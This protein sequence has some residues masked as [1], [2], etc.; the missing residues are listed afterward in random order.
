MS[1]TPLPSPPPH[2]MADCRR[3]SRHC[4]GYRPSGCA[5]GWDFRNNRRARDT[6]RALAAKARRGRRERR[7]RE[8]A[9][10]DV[11]I[12]VRS[13]L[14]AAW[15]GQWARNNG[16]TTTDGLA[17]PLA[18]A[19]TAPNTPTP[20]AETTPRIVKADSSN[21][22]L[23]LSEIMHA[24]SW[25]P[26]IRRPL[27]HARVKTR[28]SSTDVRCLVMPSGWHCVSHLTQKESNGASNVPDALDA[29]ESGL[30]RGESPCTRERK[31]LTRQ[32]VRSLSPMTDSPAG[33]KRQAR[34][35][36]GRNEN[37][38]S[39]SVS[40]PYLGAILVRAQSNG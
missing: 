25:W 20:S 3:R 7:S 17:T 24:L 37:S 10:G 19:G 31:K 33:S 15:I 2:L 6:G 12:A 9:L 8:S 5:T 30:S 40:P 4:P 34:Q 16:E 26:S 36:R 39:C 22:E 23:L 14:E 27:E 18:R 32:P 13:E 35:L 28:Y 29:K 21:R 1:A 11:E 38:A